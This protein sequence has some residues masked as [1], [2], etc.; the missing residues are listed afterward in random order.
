MFKKNFSK[1]IYLLFSILLISSCKNFFNGESFLEELEKSIEQAN[2]NEVEIYLEADMNY[3]VISPNGK[4]AIKPNNIFSVI[5]KE[6]DNYQFLY[7]NV[8]DRNTNENVPNAVEIIKTEGN[9]TDF[10]L[11]TNRTGLAIIPICAERLS[12]S[13]YPELSEKGAERDSSIILTFNKILSIDNDFDKITITSN[14]EDAKTLY[15]KEPV[16]TENVLTFAAN[17]DSII[18]VLSGTRVVTVTIPED[19]YYKVG[20]YKI[21]LGKQINYSFKLNNTTD[22]LEPQIQSIK[23]YKDPELKNELSTKVFTDEWTTEDLRKNYVSKFYVNVTGY[24]EGVGVNSLKLTE[25]LLR[26]TDGTD[27][28]EI[29]EDTKPSYFFTDINNKSFTNLGNGFYQ[30]V[31]PVTFS[32]IPDGIV[33]IRLAL[34]DYTGNVSNEVVYYVLK[35]TTLNQ[36]EICPPEEGHAAEDCVYSNFKDKI[37]GDIAKYRK[38]D[39]Q[40]IRECNGNNDFVKIK[41]ISMNESIRPYREL[42]STITI[43]K[44]L[45]G[46][47]NDEALMTEANYDM[48]S[49]TFTF[50]RNRYK[51]T[52]I[53]YYATDD[54]GNIQTLLRVIPKTPVITGT[55]TKDS[56]FH[57]YF[58]KTSYETEKEINTTDFGYYTLFKNDNF[59]TDAYLIPLGEALYPDRNGEVVHF[60]REE[61]YTSYTGLNP[62]TYNPCEKLAEFS[63]YTIPQGGEQNDFKNFRPEGNYYVYFI[64]YATYAE[65]TYFGAISEPVILSVKYD[66]ALKRNVCELANTEQ[67]PN[68]SDLPA[69][70]TLKC[71]EGP[72]NSGIY[73][74]TIIYPENFVK[75]ELLTYYV[76]VRYGT[77]TFTNNTYR[78]ST[79]TFELPTYSAKSAYK[80]YVT[81]VA[82]NPNGNEIETS[83]YKELICNNDNIA[84]T[85]RKQNAE[86]N[87]INGSRLF[88]NYSNSQKYCYPA[89]SSN[90]LGD[91]SNS[92]ILKNKNNKHELLYCCIP[93]EST[94]ST[95]TSFTI[96]ELENIEKI[97]VEYVYTQDMIF[98][99]YTK[100]L[101]PGLYTM[102]LEYTDLNQNN[103][104]TCYE[105]S[106]LG[107]VV[108]TDYMKITYNPDSNGDNTID[109]IKSEISR[110][111]SGYD[112]H[113]IEYLK[114][115]QNIDI[116]EPIYEKNT[117]GRVRG[118]SHTSG[119]GGNLNSSSFNLSFDEIGGGEN[120]IK[121]NGSYEYQKHMRYF[122]TQYILPDYLKNP[123]AYPCKVK[124]YINTDSGNHEII[125]CSDIGSPTLVRTVYSNINLNNVSVN[126]KDIEI[127]SQYGI[128]VT[129]SLKQDT[130][131]F[132]YSVPVDS[133]EIPKGYWYATI[134]HFANGDMIMT[135]P[136]QK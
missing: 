34:C 36:L 129:T 121:A 96:N 24:D 73:N 63:K 88:R 75:N 18:P 118:Y 117:E 107:P 41:N 68:Q 110:K 127:W 29:S 37:H 39:N 33:Q 78:Y 92:G 52:Y 81:L 46:Y 136:K 47:K 4:I 13:C 109:R 54:A 113:M 114:N 90:Y 120:F 112:Y 61:G 111:N 48:E 123:T 91:G 105:I 20:D 99:P 11:L 134:I 95:P 31:V 93:Y 21:T 6:A 103:G 45:W 66:S 64:P 69:N 126:D 77:I 27:V 62:F 3:G 2:I 1:L 71:T 42:D 59:S 22:T 35:D 132:N 124:S 28:T 44:V 49:T 101:E 58:Q 72:K 130:G 43:Q 86:F 9:E 17:T 67:K 116:W 57:L 122:P 25:R 16:L 97:K 100:F 26:K 5:F 23:I 51:T 60:E 40:F 76:K 65:R 115:E 85:M 38:I 133:P 102:C 14:N 53:K 87:I 98:L 89:D 56:Y 82:R 83:Y 19:F 128:E 74:V 70:F 55:E 106:T 10:K 7:W 104:I 94:Q 80:Y 119:N 135:K 125:V 50:T 30:A 12:F 32:N 108:D 84:P 8:I 15:Y 131:N 79:D